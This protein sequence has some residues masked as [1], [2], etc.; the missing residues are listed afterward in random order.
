MLQQV[1]TN[2]LETDEKI[3]NLNTEIEVI[4]KYNKKLK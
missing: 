3:E 4:R 1:I 2:P